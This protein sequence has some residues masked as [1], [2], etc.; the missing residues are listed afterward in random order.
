VERIP[1][2]HHYWSAA[3]ELYPAPNSGLSEPDRDEI[4]AKAE[5]ARFADP[6]SVWGRSERPRNRSNWPRRDGLGG[7]LLRWR[8]GPNSENK[9]KISKNCILLGRCWSNI[10]QTFTYSISQPLIP[11]SKCYQKHS[12]IIHFL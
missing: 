3:K 4:G 11:W 12:I 2:L 5:P 10:S 9:F 1:Y 6:S 7:S 8:M